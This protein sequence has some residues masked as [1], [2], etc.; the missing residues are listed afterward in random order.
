MTTPAPAASETTR[1]SQ[2]SQPQFGG[3]RV[4]VMRVGEHQGHRKARLWLNSAD[5]HLRLDVIEGE[6]TDL[7]GHG[8]LTLDEVHLPA[9]G[10]RGA[11]TVTFVPA[12]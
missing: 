9:S 4:G 5:A 7:F 6:A 8:T 2:G 1:V 3:V 12:P 11:V 10:R